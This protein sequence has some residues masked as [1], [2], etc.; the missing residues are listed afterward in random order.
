VFAWIARLVTSRPGSVLG[1]VAVLTLLLALPLTRARVDSSLESAIPADD[2]GRRYLEKIQASF[3]IEEPMV[4]AIE[5]EPTAFRAD[6]LERLDRLTRR[7]ESLDGVATVRGLTRARTV[8]GTQDTLVVEEAVPR[9]DWGSPAALRRAQA[10]TASDPLLRD[11]AAR[12]GR[13]VA[14]IIQLQ[15]VPKTGAVN[16]EE[17]VA[18][19]LTRAID[20]AAHEIFGRT[21]QVHFAGLPYL[22]GKLVATIQ[23]ELKTIAVANGAV[24]AL[25][26]L[27][28]FRSLPGLVI[29]LLTMLVATIWTMGGM[30]LLGKDIDVYTGMA[31][32]LILIIGVLDAIHLISDY[33]DEAAS[34]PDRRR[35]IASMIRGL[36][37]PCLLNS[38][39]TAYG[40]ASIMI[41]PVPI[42]QGA[43]AVMAVGMLVTYVAVMLV[44]PSMLCFWAPPPLKS[45][46]RTVTTLGRV[47][48]AVGEWV[49]AHAKPLL[50]VMI[51][52]AV[53]IGV[54]ISRLRV[55]SEFVRYFKDGD[56]V[57][58]AGRFFDDRMGGSVGFDLI[59]ETG[60]DQGL[61]RPEVLAPLSQLVETLRADPRV[62]LVHSPTDALGR[63]KEALT[64][65]FEMPRSVDEAAQLVLLLEG[66]GRSLLAE[67][68]TQSYATGR[69]RVRT[70]SLGSRELLAL[71][72]HA[73]REG[74][75]LVRRPVR[76]T[77][78]HLLMLSTADDIVDGQIMTFGLDCAGLVLIMSLAFRSLSLG[79]LSLIPN[80]IPIL[81]GLALMAATGI[82]LNNVTSINASVGLGIAIDDTVH[83]LARYR[84]EEA[85]DPKQALRNTLLAVGRPMLLS[86]LVLSLGFATLML[87]SFKNNSDTGVIAS[88]TLAIAV[89]GDLLLLPILLTLLRSRQER[90]AK[91]TT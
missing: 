18:Q 60:R 89:L 77:G 51:A 9:A 62:T 58:K 86:T 59:V 91:D 15:R 1:A 22:R 5:A 13:A 11:V 66:E 78:Q 52:V 88:S 26:L 30:T 14:L 41:N 48:V 16:P 20:D 53:M 84:R 38:I 43:G 21:A 6:F 49:A 3:K 69:V 50:V 19:H 70:R 44:V 80:I 61:L 57:A 71:A 83:F 55:E 64:G 72:R 35:A 29:P 23:H 34:Q 68:A 73:E 10:L 76:A 39:T 56:P 36:G 46:W 65:R 75:R 33:Q 82:S 63:L 32:S 81:G 42:I 74:A 67:C 87:S 4:V 47:L 54:G 31:P 17:I 45:D 85:I 24:I 12:D 40:F 2:P 79:L 8:R 37:W 7:V 25:L 28:V 90:R 27:V